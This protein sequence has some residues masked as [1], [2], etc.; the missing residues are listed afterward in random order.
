MCFVKNLWEDSII[1]FFIIFC[2]EFKKFCHSTTPFSPTRARRQQFFSPDKSL[3]T[4]DRHRLHITLRDSPFLLPLS[5]TM[6]RRRQL[7]GTRHGKWTHLFMVSWLNLFY[8]TLTDHGQTSATF[9]L[10]SKIGRHLAVVGTRHG[11]W[12]HLLLS[13]SLM[14]PSSNFPFWPTTARRRQLFVL[15]KKS[16]DVW[17]S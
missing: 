9:Y 14:S 15:V 12:T 10:G 8:L 1:L 13:Y 3:L 11:T 2:N 17:P 5:P 6:A 7:V 16:A 4:S